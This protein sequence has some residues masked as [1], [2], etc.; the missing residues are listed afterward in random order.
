MHATLYID[1][2]AAPDRCVVRFTVHAESGAAPLGPRIE[3]EQLF[4][5]MKS[6]LLTG[7]DAVSHHVTK[8]Y[9]IDGERVTMEMK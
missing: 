9:G 2:I 6:A 8:T 1:R 7:M 4:P 5:D 3:L